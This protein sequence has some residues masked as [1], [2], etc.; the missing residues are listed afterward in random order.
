MTI[1]EFKN[2]LEINGCKKCDLEFQDGLN[3]CCIAR[4][5]DKYR[6]MIVGEA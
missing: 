3:G 4:G 2:H 5:T 6:R 1:Y